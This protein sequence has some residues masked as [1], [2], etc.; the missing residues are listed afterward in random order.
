MGQTNDFWIMEPG[1]AL[2]WI[3]LI[4]S[5]LV[6]AAVSWFV[7]DK[8][9]RFKINLISIACILTF[10]G[11]F[12]Y[13]YY[14]SMD[15][16]YDRAY[17]IMGGFNWWGELPLHLC[18][19][20]LLL[21]PMALWLDNR[22]LKGFCFFVGPLGALMALLMP[23]IGFSG[24]P[25]FMPRMLGFYLTHYM[26]IIE[27]LSIVTF[28]L[29]YPRFTDVF[30]SSL[31]LFIIAAVMFVISMILRLSGLNPRANYFFTI[32]TEGNPVFEMFKRWISVPLFYLLPCIPLLAA[33]ILMVTS[34]FKLANL[35]SGKN[36]RDSQ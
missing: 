10:L 27:A 29:Y 31:I 36:S 25:I 8:S 24:Y 34:G 17:A 15:A 6:L 1:C 22:H 19:I 20:N 3:M 26:L 30:S 21:I 2:F 32:E 35:I 4:A 9:E 16:E 5:I 23:S 7:R 11:F 13:K 12:V 33:Y 18:N 14:L 28:G